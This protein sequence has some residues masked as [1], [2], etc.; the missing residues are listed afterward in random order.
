MKRLRILGLF[1]LLGAPMPLMSQALFSDGYLSITTSLQW[2][3]ITN[4]SHQYDL[5]TLPIFIAGASSD[6]DIM[7]KIQFFPEVLRLGSYYSDNSDSLAPGE[8]IKYTFGSMEVLY[9]MLNWE[10]IQLNL[11]GSL[12]HMGFLS[13]DF[14]QTPRWSI[15]FSPKVSAMFYL[16]HH[17]LVQIPFEVPLSLYSHNFSSYFFMKTGAEVV[18]D[19]L[20]PIKNPSPETVFF[21]IGY[22][23]EYNVVDGAISQ[24]H[25]PYIKFSLLY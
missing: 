5:L 12:G 18:F 13:P 4:K 25:R 7:T 3:H 15:Y 9:S 20:G 17:V 6:H 1:L 16:G 22:E 23:Y 2:E 24:Y 19:P 11:G 14:A 8:V 21:A 10:F